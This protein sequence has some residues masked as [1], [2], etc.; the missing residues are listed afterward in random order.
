MSNQA[1]L[2]SVVSKLKVVRKF[3]YLGAVISKEGARIEQ[4]IKSRDNNVKNDLEKNRKICLKSKV[5]AL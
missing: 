1:I 4:N 5:I 2:K 3:K